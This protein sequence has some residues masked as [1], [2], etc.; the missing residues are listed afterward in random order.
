MIISLAQLEVF[1]FICAR[2]AGIF[3]NIPFFSTRNT[4]MQVKAALTIWLAAVLWFVVPISRLP[5]VNLTQFVFALATE[6][7]IGFTLGYITSVIFA[8]LQSAGELMDMQMGLSVAQVFDPMY[9]QAITLIGRFFSF[10][11]LVIF[12]S[13]DGHH[14]LLAAFYQSFSLIPAGQAA[15]FFNPN[16]LVLLI[17]VTS[18]FWMTAIQ[19]SAPILL[20]IFLSDFSFGIVSRVAP[21]VNVFM[22]GF[23]VKPLL[24]IFGILVTLPFIVKYLQKM[25]ELMG[26]TMI[27]LLLIIK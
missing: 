7:I 10:I 24:G 21:Q 9:G 27:Q 15:N 22:L 20:L 13:L 6:V 17:G 11:A 23:Q 18:G 3:I 8:A 2:I 25:I 26:Q 16:L 12:I 4:P 1:L 19:L 5:V 14:L